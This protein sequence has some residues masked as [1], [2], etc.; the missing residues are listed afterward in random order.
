MLYLL[1]G[2]AAKDVRCTLICPPD[3]EIY[4]AAN[5]ANLTVVP[6]AMAGDLDVG[7]VPRLYDWLGNHR[8]DLLH[9]HS[10]RGADVWGGLA[11]R[12]AAVPAVLTRRVDNPDVP[13][14]GSLKYRLYKRVI[15]ISDQIRTELRSAGVPGTKLRLVHSACAGGQTPGRTR[16][17]FLD[18]FDL[19]P[20]QT[21]VFCV[22]QLIARKGHAYLLDAWTEVLSE[23][24]DARLLLFGQGSEEEHLRTQADRLGIAHALRFAGFRADL[25]EFLGLADLL[26]HPALHEGLGVCLLEA[27]AAG[28]PVVAARAGGIPEAVAEGESGLLVTP[29]QAAELAGAILAMLKDSGRRRQ[30]AAVG[31]AH[32][33]RH[34]SL[35]AMVSGNLEVYREVLGVMFRS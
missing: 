14:V 21:A 22:A 17:Q 16:E 12:R 9:V 18:A 25:H 15:A 2:L 8:P 13:F 6:V 32:V 30:M 10:R 5:Q 28:V 27:Q 35:E 23:Y 33:A 29:G 26:V 3:S 24:P 4:S 31:P 19:E 34:F 7:F 1:D 20:G 11:A